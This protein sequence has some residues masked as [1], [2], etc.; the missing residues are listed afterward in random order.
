MNSLPKTLPAFTADHAAARSTRVGGSEVGSLFGW[1][2]LTR[3]GLYERKVAVLEGRDDPDEGEPR[4]SSKGQIDPRIRGSILEPAVARLVAIHAPELDVFEF[5]PGENYWP[6]PTSE[7][8]G[9]TPDFGVLHPEWGPGVLSIKTANFFVY[10]HW[11]QVAEGLH[12][13][14]AEVEP[15]MGYQLQVQAELACAP[16]EAFFEPGEPYRWGCIA[17]LVGGFDHLEMFPA[18]GSQADGCRFNSGDRGKVGAYVPNAT[19]H[20]QL[21]IETD[22]FW[23]QVED[24]EPPAADFEKDYE[25]LARIQGSMG[26][27]EAVNLRADEAFNEAGKTFLIAR[28]E[29]SFA[30]KIKRAAGAELAEIAIRNG[31]PKQAYGKWITRSMIEISESKCECGRMTRKASRRADIRAAKVRP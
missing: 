21:M 9:S 26:I 15:T 12:G 27:G 4:I 2:F 30:R 10:R 23:S 14:G 8:L 5:P 3:L 6:H 1:G 16:P 31:N 25:T 24:R 11:Q 29:E 20:G 22:T 18:A 28:D 13:E 17:T 7:H 19:I